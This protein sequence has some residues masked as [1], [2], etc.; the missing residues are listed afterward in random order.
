M[1]PTCVGSDHSTC[2][3]PKT[4]KITALE[5]IERYASGS[6]STQVGLDAG[7]SCVSILKVLRDHGMRP[8]T[9]GEALRKYPYAE[10]AEKYL[11]GKSPR[12]LSTEYGSPIFDIYKILRHSRVVLRPRPKG[13]QHPL[14]R[15]GIYKGGD[16]YLLS[17][18]GRVHR[19]VVEKLVGRS[20]QPWEDAHHLNENRLDNRKE[21]LVGMPNREHNRFHTFLRHRKLHA[22]HELLLRFGRPETEHY[23]RFTVVDLK[24]A[25]LELPCPKDT[26]SKSTCGIRGCGAPMY[27]KNRCSRHYQRLIARKRGY[28][29]AGHGRL[30]KFTGKRRNTKISRA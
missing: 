5:I 24:Q 23:F 21:N 6:T 4:Y 19:L 27:G 8:R 11:S 16:G 12:E 7:V 15:G 22:S 30:A 25:Q 20:L 9:S 28:W 2:L 10:I 26:L 17:K 14:W 29:K 18:E 1:P 13:E 3:N